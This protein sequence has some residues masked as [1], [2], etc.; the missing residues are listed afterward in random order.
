MLIDGPWD[1]LVNF[2]DRTFGWQLDRPSPF[3]IWDWGEYPGFP[4]LAMRAEGAQ[5]RAGPAGRRRS[6]SCRGGSTCT[7]WPPSRARCIV[8]FQICL[9]HW[10]Y[11]YIPWFMPFVA[12]ALLAPRTST[13]DEAVA[14]VEEPVAEPAAGKRRRL[15]WG[16]RG[17]RPARPQALPTPPRAP[18]G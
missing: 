17:L 14:L 4:D 7:A 12:L 13:A 2:W 3:S 5:G 1:G 10:H 15:A 9:T 11:L 6:T 8:G 16:G 18:A